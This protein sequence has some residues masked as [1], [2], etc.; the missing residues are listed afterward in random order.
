[1]QLPGYWMHVGDP[2]S[3]IAAE[4]VINQVKLNGYNG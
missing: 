1:M 4:A 3:L 2:N